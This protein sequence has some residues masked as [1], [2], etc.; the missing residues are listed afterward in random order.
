MRKRLFLIGVLTLVLCLVLV[1]CNQSVDVELPEEEHVHDWGEG[2]IVVEAAC[3]AAGIKIYT[4]DCGDTKTEA[5]TALE[6]TWDSGKITTPAS[7]FGSGIKTISCTT[8]G[9]SKTEL[10]PANGEHLWGDPVVT[11][12]ATCTT[13]GTQM[14]YCEI[15]GQGKSVE[16]IP[17]LGH[18]W[19]SSFTTDPS[20]MTL[21]RCRRCG[22][23][24]YVNTRYG[25]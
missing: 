23:N 6:H 21:I 5:I 16:G 7:C 9:Q 24:S 12:P 20:G 10:I 19:P 15:C 13:P 1:S 25:N 8:C 22:Y 11:M 3:S 4:C 14:S 18:E 17:A 2:S